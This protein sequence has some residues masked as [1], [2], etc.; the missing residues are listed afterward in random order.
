MNIGIVPDPVNQPDWPAIKAFL[1]PAAK[2]GGVPVLEKYEEVWTVEEGNELLAAATGRILPED[3]IGE[4]ILCGGKHAVLW[5]APLADR[6]C[7]WFRTEGMTKARIYGR[8]GWHRLLASHGW[9]II[10]AEGKYTGFERV[11]T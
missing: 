7:D 11:L 9:Q 3:L 10:G 8:K 5:A 6:M 2:R 1:E 4:I